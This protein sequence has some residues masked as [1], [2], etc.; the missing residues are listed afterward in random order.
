VAACDM[1]KVVKFSGAKTG[2]IG[3]DRGNDDSSS[4]AKSR[5]LRCASN[6]GDGSQAEG[7]LRPADGGSTP[8]TSPAWATEDFFFPCGPLGALLR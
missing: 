8:M 2:M 1:G 7:A 3:G 6:G 5:L 4:S